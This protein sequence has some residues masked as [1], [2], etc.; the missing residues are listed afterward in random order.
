MIASV[1]K[2]SG[3]NVPEWMLSLKKQSQNRKKWLAVRPPD[4]ERMTD[5]G[6]RK[7]RRKIEGEGEGEGKGKGEGEGNGKGKGKERK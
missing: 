3:C 4:R 5:S 1:I 2:Q 7:K 6:P